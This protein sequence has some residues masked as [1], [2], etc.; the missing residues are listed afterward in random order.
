L[1]LGKGQQDNQQTAMLSFILFIAVMALVSGFQL[2]KSIP[3]SRIGLAMMCDSTIA[4]KATIMLKKKKIQEVN[5]LKAEMATAGDS[6]AVNVRIPQLGSCIK[7]L[8]LSY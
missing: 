1:R 8:L 6:H 4:S 7:V 2:L 5:A 3:A